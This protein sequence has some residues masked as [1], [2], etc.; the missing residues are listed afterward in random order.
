MV[1][2]ILFNTSNVALYCQYFS[3]IEREYW[4]ELLREFILMD[5]LTVDIAFPYEEMFQS[6]P[7]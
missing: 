2:S 5:T 6:L 4:S 1:P 7:P 3:F